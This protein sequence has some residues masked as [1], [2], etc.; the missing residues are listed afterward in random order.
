MKSKKKG[1]RKGC[2]FYQFTK[3]VKVQ[4]HKEIILIEEET[5]DLFGGKESRKILGFPA[6]GVIDVSPKKCAALQDDRYTAFVQS[7]SVNRKLIGG[8]KF[9]YENEHWDG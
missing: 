2:G 5:G 8:T 3:S 4:A 7:T 6:F 1:F 9:L